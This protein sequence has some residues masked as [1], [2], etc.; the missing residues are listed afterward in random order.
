MASEFELCSKS[1]IDLGEDTINSFTEDT[2]R[3]RICGLVYPDYIKYLLC[4]YPWK[5][6]ATKAQLARLNMT[7]LNKWAYA[8]QLPGDLLNLVAVYN[9]SAVGVTPI[10]GFE[11]SGEMILTNENYI[12]LD[13]QTEP[14]SKDFPA[15][16]AEFVVKAF[17]SKIA[18][19]ITD[20]LKIAEIMHVKAFGLPSDN[21]NGGEFAIAKRLDSLQNASSAILSNDLLAARFR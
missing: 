15:Y 21:N 4:L 6:N 1:L 10:T 11:R 14:N 17:A 9:S 12:Y 20:D 2:S 16:F 13:Y 5:F 18:L 8:Y 3:S 19:S 7:P